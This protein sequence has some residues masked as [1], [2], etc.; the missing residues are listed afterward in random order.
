MKI[1]EKL[2]DQDADADEREIVD[3]GVERLVTIIV[4]S[5]FVLFVGFLLNETIRSILLMI[6]LFPLRQNAGG[7]HLNSKYACSIVSVLCLIGMLLIIKYCVISYYIAIIVLIIFSMPIVY[8]APVGNRNRILDE[9]EK[10]VFGNRTRM[11]WLIETIVFLVLW[12]LNQSGW[13]III[14]LS[15]VVTGS[16][17][18]IGRFQEMLFERR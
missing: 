15:V 9:D 17:V 13:Y 2:L 3:F 4:A 6:C 7:F 12:S 11:I 8:W 10:I 16:L 1:A 5:F 18:S 14:V